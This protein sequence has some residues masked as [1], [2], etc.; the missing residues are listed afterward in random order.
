VIL[1]NT[2]NKPKS[3]M[4]INSDCHIPISTIYRRLQTLHDNGLLTVTGSISIEGKKY[5]MY[6]SKLDSIFTYFDGKQV[7]I[8]LIYNENDQKMQKVW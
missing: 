2:R 7:E 4:E 1:E 3:A 5:F 8:G 6:K